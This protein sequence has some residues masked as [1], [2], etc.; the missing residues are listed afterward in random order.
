MRATRDWMLTIPA[1]KFDKKEVE[2]RLKKYQ[3]IGQLEKGKTDTE[4][5]HWQVFVHGTIIGAAIRFDTLR[6]K[7]DGQVHL[8]PRCGTIL[9]C[10]NYVTK[11]DTA[12]AKKDDDYEYITEH[13]ELS[14][15]RIRQDG[16][17]NWDDLRKNARTKSRISNEE[18]YQEII[19]G[20]TAGQI[21]NDHPELGMQ[22][23]K[24]KALEN[25]IKEEQ[26]RG[27]Q[28]EDRENIEVNYLWG[29]PGA[30][31]SWHVLNEAGYDRRDIYRKNGYQHVWDNYQG[32]RVLILEDFT[33][34]IGIEELLQVTDIYATELDAR[35]SNHYAGWEVVW[36]ISNLRLDDLLKKY[37]KEL[38]P[39]LVSRITNVYLMEDREMINQNE[40]WAGQLRETRE[41]PWL[42]PKSIPLFPDLVG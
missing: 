9:D 12:V 30:G 18:I 27:L 21:I 1:S 35:Y 24:I 4:Y 33:G 15:I 34:Q 22:F 6:N 25:G 26:F 7:F 17:D 11:L 13:P 5:L 38:R 10:I 3:Y 14:P 29:P 31:K 20:K 36:I 8:E 37:P 2:N 41:K 28:T 32:Q 40:L 39:A 23:L 42:Y 19:S 16:Q